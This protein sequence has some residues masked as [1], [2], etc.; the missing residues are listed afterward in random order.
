MNLDETD[1]IIKDKV[2]E[3]MSGKWD[4]KFDA[5][6]IH[7]LKRRTFLLNHF[8]YKDGDFTFEYDAD[9][10]VVHCS[11]VAELS[12]YFADTNS[13]VIHSIMSDPSFDRAYAAFS[14]QWKIDGLLNQ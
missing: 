1:Q 6:H 4:E 2:D 12:L 10:I 11:D 7:M 5:E 8:A 3:I 14:R 9:R 13:H